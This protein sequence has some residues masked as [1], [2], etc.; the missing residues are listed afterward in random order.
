MTASKSSPRTNLLLHIPAGNLGVVSESL[1]LLWLTV[2][3]PSKEY[4]YRPGKG[5]SSP[6]L[7]RPSTLD[8]IIIIIINNL[9]EQEK[10]TYASYELSS[11]SVR[12]MKVLLADRGF[13]G[14]ASAAG[15][16]STSM[17]LGHHP[18]SYT[19]GSSTY[20]DHQ[21]SMDSGRSRGAGQRDRVAGRASAV[22][23]AD[24]E[25]EK[26]LADDDGDPHSGEDG[27]IVDGLVDKDV[28]RR[29]RGQIVV[30][31]KR[32]GMLTM[33][34]LLV[35]G[36]FIWWEDRNEYKFRKKRGDG[37]IPLQGA[38]YMREMT[39]RPV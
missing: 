10:D 39:R 4:C 32:E 1:S 31:L 33:K 34:K 20:D 13:K 22:G 25:A 18:T 23:I 35:P 27:S 37:G 30:L 24:H 38:G 15:I 6:S 3:R 21:R 2:C 11:D 5:L 26:G 12:S 7:C 17:R 36:W 16:A 14:G 8:A 28:R 29:G 9:S 19:Q